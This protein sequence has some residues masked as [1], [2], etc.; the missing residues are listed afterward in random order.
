M[1]GTREEIKR[2]KTQTTTTRY[3]LLLVLCE[4][5]ERKEGTQ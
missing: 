2:T 1:N 3:I 5:N 4:G